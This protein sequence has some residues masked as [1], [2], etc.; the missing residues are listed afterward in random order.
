[1]T[2]PGSTWHCLVMLPRMK[3]FRNILHVGASP[4]TGNRYVESPRILSGHSSLSSFISDSYRILYPGARKW[5]PFQRSAGGIVR[6]QWHRSTPSDSIFLS[7]GQSGAFLDPTSVSPSF[8]LTFAIMIDHRSRTCILRAFP[9]SRQATA[10]SLVTSAVLV[11]SGI[12]TS[13]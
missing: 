11:A 10:Y 5:S 1:M 2:P 4:Q 9:V 12:A 6:G 7:S 8:Q 13:T 3:C